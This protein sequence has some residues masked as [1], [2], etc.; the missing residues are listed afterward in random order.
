MCGMS[1]T[2]VHL[3]VMEE[4]RINRTPAAHR[5]SHKDLRRLTERAFKEIN[6]SVLPILKFILKAEINPADIVRAI[7]RADEAYEMVHTISG[8]SDHLL[9]MDKSLTEV[10]VMGAELVRSA[11]EQNKL[12]LVDL[13]LE[14]LEIEGGIIDISDLMERTQLWHKPQWLSKMFQRGADLEKCKTNP[15]ELVLGK[16]YYKQAVKLEMIHLLIEN[17]TPL[18]NSSPCSSIIN[19]VVDC[20]LKCEN[21]TVDALELVCEK[22]DFETQQA[23]DKEGKTPWHVTLEYTWKKIGVEIC[24]V[25]RKYPIDPSITDKNGQRAD[26]GKKGNDDRVKILREREAEIIKM[27]KKPS[28]MTTMAETGGKTMEYKASVPSMNHTVCK[29][30]DVS[31][32]N[33][34][35]TKHPTENENSTAGPICER[36]G[37]TSFGC[38][39]ASTT[40]TEESDSRQADDVSA[41][42]H[43]ATTESDNKHGACGESFGSESSADGLKEEYDAEVALALETPEPSGTS[44]SNSEHEACASSCETESSE[45]Q[46]LWI[47]ERRAKIKKKLA[48]HKQHRKVFN[49]KVRILSQG[50]F[51]GNKKHC[52]PVTHEKG[53]ELYEMRVNKKVRIIWEIVPKYFPSQ[54]IYKEIIRLWDIVLDHDNIHHRAQ[55]ILEDEAFLD[56]KILKPKLKSLPTQESNVHNNIRK[57]QTFVAFL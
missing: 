21:G 4:S 18:P 32:G 6:F 57:P 55:T 3:N 17:R 26:F 40:A 27:C 14:S 49:A 51:V 30:K 15:M 50:E 35:K 42:E 33:E 53:L 52:K 19:E 45:E 34:P 56:T 38:V 10:R 1:V 37:G 39:A 20:T 29:R 44:E 22:F 8:Q 28:K 41:V 12:Q 36:A 54:H 7:K 48:R 13:F 24:K 5:Y 2:T 23:C 16:P 9:K 11:I 47:I 25:L 31:R 43:S 46:T